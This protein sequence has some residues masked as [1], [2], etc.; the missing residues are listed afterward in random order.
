VRGDALFT[1]SGQPAEGKTAAD[2]EAAL[3][4]EVKR[5]ADQGVTPEELSRVKTQIVA[6]QVYKRDS[7]MA[8]AMEMGMFE[9][10]GF[11]WR[12]YDKLLDKIKSVTSDEIQA[13]AKKYFGD[14]TLTVAALDPQPLD[15]SAK[16]RPSVPL[17]PY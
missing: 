11:N 2:L 3:R 4:A 13:V 1:L 14:D 17:R 8:Q 15:K 6:S 5:I 16:R 12:D 7:M 9:A 10:A